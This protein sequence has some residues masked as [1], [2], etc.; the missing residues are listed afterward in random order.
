[1]GKMLVFTNA[2]EGRDDEFNEWYDNVHLAEVVSLPG[3][4]AA[5]RHELADAQM[6]PEQS[7]RYLAIYEY[8]GDAA[9]ALAALGAGAATMNMSDAL[10]GDAKLVLFEDR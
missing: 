5:T 6:F 4:V 7:H 10:A 2:V 1:M 8:K 9:D 3:F